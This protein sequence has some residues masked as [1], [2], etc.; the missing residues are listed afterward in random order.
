MASKNKCNQCKRESKETE[1]W[2]EVIELQ[3]HYY[4]CPRCYR[5]VSLNAYRDTLLERIAALDIP[6]DDPSE[7]LGM[8]V[9]KLRCI[10]IVRD[11]VFN[12]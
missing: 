3:R 1:G 6:Y 12:V 4:L 9:M 8:D 7:K 5:N 11:T 10:A 2:W